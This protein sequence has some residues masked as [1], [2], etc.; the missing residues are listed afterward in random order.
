MGRPLERP[1]PSGPLAGRI[2]AIRDIERN[3]SLPSFRVA[4]SVLRDTVPRQEAPNP[5]RCASLPTA[6]SLGETEVLPNSRRGRIANR[7]HN[8]S[9]T[10]HGRTYRYR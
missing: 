5:A 6:R 1:P 2:T 3:P 9:E 10:D 4:I 7:A 8:T